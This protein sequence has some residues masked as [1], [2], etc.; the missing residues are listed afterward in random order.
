M[1]DPDYLS[2]NK[3]EDTHLTL[4]DNGKLWGDLD[5]PEEILE[6]R[7]ATKQKKAAAR[8][9]KRKI[10][11]SDSS[12][13]AK[14]KTAAVAKGK[15]KAKA[16]T[17]TAPA[18]AASAPPTHAVCEPSGSTAPVPSTSTQPVEADQECW[19]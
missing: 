2:A 13:P 9:A 16:K 14:K 10:E 1:V 18:A 11:E 15:G 7:D 5:D 17:P 6:I 4:L 3:S 8:V 19:D 12:L